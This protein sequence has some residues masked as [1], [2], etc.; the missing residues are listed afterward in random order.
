MSTAYV[1]QTADRLTKNERTLAAQLNFDPVKQREYFAKYPLPK[2]NII[3]I[4]FRE[5]VREVV[6]GALTKP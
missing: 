4:Y 5:D 3:D 1:K 2:K 6:Q